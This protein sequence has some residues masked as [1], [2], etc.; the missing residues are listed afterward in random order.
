M[1]VFVL[2]DFIWIQ[3]PIHAKEAHLFFQLAP[4]ELTTI[5]LLKSVFHAQ[6][7]APLVF[8]QV[9]APVVRQVMT[10]MQDRAKQD[11]EMD[12][13]LALKLVILDQILKR[14]VKIA[15]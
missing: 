3:L 11:V 9:L 6:Q 4:T 5:I 13:F 2:M 12:S 1:G 7:H 10:S 15:K 14:A 8:L